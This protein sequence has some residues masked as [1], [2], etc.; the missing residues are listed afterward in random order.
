MYQVD[1]KQYGIPFD[2]GMVGFWYNKSQFAKAGITAAPATWDDLLA[3]IGKLKTAGVTPVAL[4]GKDTWTG[5]FYLGLPRGPRMRQ[6]RHGQG[7]H[8]R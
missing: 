1:G 5:A 2:L 4:A 8:D 3:D 7:G 6:G